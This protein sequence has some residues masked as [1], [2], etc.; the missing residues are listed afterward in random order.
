MTVIVGYD[1]LILV[2]S[3]CYIINKARA[4]HFLKA[5]LKTEITSLDEFDQED[6]STAVLHYS[7]TVLPC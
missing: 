6:R 1:W 3:T 7:F 2:N 4:E 5:V